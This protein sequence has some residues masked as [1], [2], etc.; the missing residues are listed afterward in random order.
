MSSIDAKCLYNTGWLYSISV[1]SLR[2]VTASQPSLSAKVRAVA[3]M[4]L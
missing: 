4:S 1:D 2:V 3:K